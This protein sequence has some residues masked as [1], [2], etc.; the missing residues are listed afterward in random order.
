[1]STLREPETGRT[2]SILLRGGR[3]HGHPDAHA[4]V[5][6]GGR[7]AWIGEDAAAASHL[8]SVDR[9]VDLDGAL[10]TAA[11]SDAHVHLTM[12]GQGLDGIDLSETNSVGE[13]LRLVETAARHLRGRPVYAHSWDETKWVEGRPITARELD[14]ATYGGV[15]YMPRVDAHSASVSSAMAA[16]ARVHGLDGWDGSG[17]VTRE[18]FAAVTN[19]FT[20]AMTDADREHYLDLALRAASERG[21]GL[22]HETGADHLTSFADVHHVLEAGQRPAR[23]ATVAYWGQ[24]VDDHTEAQELGHYLGVAG[25]AGDLCADGS[26]GSRTAHVLDSYRDAPGHGYGYLSADQI[27]QHVI[28]CT[29]AGLQAGGHVIGDAALHTMAEG[30]RRASEVVGTEAMIAARHRWEHVELPDAE[31]LATMA[32]LGIWASVQP[33]FDGLWGGTEG[34]YA[35]RLGEERALAVV[36]LRSMLDA[37]V[38]VALGSDSPVTRIDPWRGVRYAVWHHNE[39]QRLTV[40]EAFEAHTVGG[41]ALAGRPGGTLA[42]GEPASYVVW[43]TPDGDLP[44]TEDGLPDLAAEPDLPLPVA[45]LTVVDGHVTFDREGV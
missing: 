17:V 41:Y 8:D 26:F 14:R 36:P 44:H 19:A 43:D 35:A 7:I 5:S 40:A 37:G 12:T 2:P 20:S 30:F 38:R 27:A 23:T 13:A 10:V 3:L 24:L 15:V 25:F 28:A 22:V 6:R 42:L 45:R 16:V 39:E 4:M 1:M 29:R 33:A 31:V 18:A 9:V 34:M 21:V 32:E 11:F